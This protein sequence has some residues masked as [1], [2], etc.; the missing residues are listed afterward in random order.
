MRPPQRD[1]SATI[2]MGLLTLAALLLVGFVVIAVV[3]RDD[4]GNGDAGADPSIPDSRAGG[5]VEPTVPLDTTA[6]TTAENVAPSTV[7][8]AS[9]PVAENPRFS[10]QTADGVPDPEVFLVP[11]GSTQL[12]LTWSY[13]GF[14]PGESFEFEWLIDGVLDPGSRSE[15]TNQGGSVGDFFGCVTNGGGLADGLYEAIWI[16]SGQQV[17]THSLFVGGGREPVTIGIQN[18]RT[19]PV[20]EV[21]WT[22]VGSAS[23]GLP[24]NPTEVPPGGRFETTMPTGNYRTVVRDCAGATVFEEAEIVFSIDDTLTLTP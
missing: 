16:V 24:A 10:L 1:R 9:G 20:C 17:F 12:C 6:I 19:E 5:L 4:P 7:S 15:G 18:N 14:E 21:Y 8:P 11:P 23:V 22:P 13:S 2:G 3:G